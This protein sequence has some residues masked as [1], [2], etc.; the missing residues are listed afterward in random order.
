MLKED[1]VAGCSVLRRRLGAFLLGLLLSGVLFLFVQVFSSF[2]SQTWSLWGAVP[3]YPTARH[4]SYRSYY[5]IV[6]YVALLLIPFCLGCGA[7]L[8]WGKRS[9]HLVRSSLGAG[10]LVWFGASCSPFFFALWSVA[11][12][13]TYCATHYCHGGAGIGFYLIIAILLIGLLFVILGAVIT[14]QIMKYS[15]KSRERR[16][17]RGIVERRAS[18]P[19]IALRLLIAFFLGLLFYYIAAIATS[20]SVYYNTTDIFYFFPLCIGIAAAFSVGRRSNNS[21]LLALGTGLATW[22]GISCFY[23]YHAYLE[24]LASQTSCA[25]HSCYPPIVAGSSVAIATMDLTTGV[26]FVL[27]G[28]WIVALFMRG[29]LMVTSA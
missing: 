24:G 25:L 12:T 21:I 17:E 6:P 20:L 26:P 28:A 11:Q 16:A 10:L 8:I 7:A 5:S 1:S 9:S 13:D 19:A 27:L 18:K 4:F 29:S 23:V 15:L 22:L 3:D 14:G 2:F